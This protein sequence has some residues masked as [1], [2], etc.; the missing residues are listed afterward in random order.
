MTSVVN[1]FRLQYASNLQISGMI[2]IH[3]S[4]YILPVPNA[5]LAL[6]G[7]IG[8]PNVELANF[9]KWCEYEYEHIYWVPG[10]LELSSQENEKVEIDHKIFLLRHWLLKNNIH[11][12]K[13]CKREIQ[14]VYSPY[15]TLLM[16]PTWDSDMDFGNLNL[17][18]WNTETTTV[19]TKV[20]KPHLKRLQ[21]AE[22]DWIL[23][24]IRASL[25]PVVC[26]TSTELVANAPNV[27][28]P[29]TV[30]ASL[31]GRVADS[32]NKTFTGMSDRGG[33]WGGVNMYGH[34]NYNRCA[35]VEFAEEL[36]VARQVEDSIYEHLQLKEPTGFSPKPQS[37]SSVEYRILF[38]ELR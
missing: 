34:S 23:K 8:R 13:L 7:N 18:T 9:L 5:H 25:T 37:K 31:F 1:R 4:Q 16:T 32:S 3:P 36:N 26:L 6:L 38:P 20:K 29:Q 28:N 30:K 24:K 33:P 11:R 19:L 15:L 14:T 12:V 35:F 22:T 17:Y 10:C 21:D 2:K 27:F